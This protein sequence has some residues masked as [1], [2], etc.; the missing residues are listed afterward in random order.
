MGA[1]REE[2][3]GLHA[4]E[5][6]MQTTD[7]DHLE[8]ELAQARQAEHVARVD[9]AHWKRVAEALSARVKELEAADLKLTN[10]RKQA[11]HRRRHAFV[12]P[13]SEPP[14]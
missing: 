7:R 1:W 10:K 6:V 2:K 3:R 12:Q 9:C 4:N 14:A 13:V 5:P 11:R 8:A